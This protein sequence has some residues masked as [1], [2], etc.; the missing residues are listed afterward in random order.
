M[1][2][3]GEACLVR[4]PD[5]L[6]WVSSIY[7]VPQRVED[8]A[9]DRYIAAHDWTR[10]RR[11]FA[12]WAALDSYRNQH[13]LP[14]SRTT[15]SVADYDGYDIQNVL[16]ET[17]TAE[18]DPEQRASARLLLIDILRDSAIVRTN[19]ALYS[20]VLSRLD[21]LTDPRSK[22]RPNRAP[23]EFAA[24]MDRFAA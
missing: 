14:P 3:T 22:W 6:L 1:A 9:V 13:S 17:S 5:G 20:A 11:S 18:H 23:Q 10:T 8:E 7:A 15:Q 16:D 21:E 4:D 19:N 24:A 2:P 12:T